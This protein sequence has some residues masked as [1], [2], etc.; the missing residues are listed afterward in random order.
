MRKR[1]YLPPEAK[2]VCM[3][4]INYILINIFY[5]LLNS[6]RLTLKNKVHHQFTYNFIVKFKV[7]QLPWTYR[8]ETNFVIRQWLLATGD[9]AARISTRTW[10]RSRTES[11]RSRQL[12]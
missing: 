3:Y 9:R 11:P 10:L 8:R 6:Y 2:R 1:L 12:R 4:L 7:L 5:E